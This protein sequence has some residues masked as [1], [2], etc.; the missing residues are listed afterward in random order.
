M[1]NIEKIVVHP[2]LLAKGNTKIAIYGIGHMRDERLN[3]AFETNNIKFKRP[4]FEKE[5]WFNILVVHQ[6]KF[7]GMFLGVPKRQSLM[8]SIFPSFMD[9]VIWGHEHESIPKAVRCE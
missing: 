8:E 3:H 1:T 9:L 6:N 7:K 5:N 2:I 4:K